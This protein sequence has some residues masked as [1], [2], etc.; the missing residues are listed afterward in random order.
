MKENN[1]IIEKYKNYQISEIQSGYR[2]KTYLLNDNVTKYIYQ[3]YL[4][5]IKYQVKRKNM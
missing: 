4:G 1:Y 5:D 2:C 3:V